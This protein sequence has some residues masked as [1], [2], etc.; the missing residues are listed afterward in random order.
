MNA[1]KSKYLISVIVTV[2]N[3]RKKFQRAINSIFSQSITNFEIIIIDDG[4]TDGI[5]KIIIPLTKS[6]PFIKYLRHSNRGPALSLNAGILISEGNYVAFLDSD[7]EYGPYYLERRIEFMQKEKCDLLHSPATLIGKEK[8]FFVP[9]VR[10][11]KRLIHL[12]K[13][14][15]GATF[16][17]KKEIFLK[18]GGFSN[19][20]SYDS[21]FLKKAKLKF[22]VKEF[23]EYSYI[24]YRDS[25]DSILTREKQKTIYND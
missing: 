14:V 12:N 5:E 22:K 17:G 23:I 25:R 2:F 24:Y 10:N 18:L 11:R 15:I 9:D 1:L 19:V 8:D 20:Y 3:R 7:D 21:I 16:F 6:H 4:S 13:C